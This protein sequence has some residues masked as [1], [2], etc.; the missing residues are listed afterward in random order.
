LQ[1]RCIGT[2]ADDLAR[3]REIRC[4]I[5]NDGRIGPNRQF[6]MRDVF[7]VGVAREPFFVGEQPD[8]DAEFVQHVDAAL[9]CGRRDQVLLDRIELRV[10]DRT[11]IKG[12]D[13]KR[14]PKRLD[15]KPHADSR[16]A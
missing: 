11:S 1:Q 16:T 14:D 12:P 9:S 2:G 7:T 3:G 10:D 6:L 8:I 4:E 5:R 15:Q 13:R